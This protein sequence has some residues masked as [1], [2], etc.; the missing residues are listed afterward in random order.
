M[1]NCQDLED[2]AEDARMLAYAVQPL[3]QEIDAISVRA[4]NSTSLF[5]EIS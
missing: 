4:S 5:A 2:L 3:L 1:G